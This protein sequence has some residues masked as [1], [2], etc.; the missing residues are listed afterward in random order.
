[1][2]GG[3]VLVRVRVFNLLNYLQG[4]TVDQKKD[5]RE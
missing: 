3:S 5:N 1:M 4:R 2:D